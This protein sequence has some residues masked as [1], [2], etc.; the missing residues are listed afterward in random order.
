[1]HVKD[2]FLT[3]SPDYVKDWTIPNA[4]REFIQNSL[5]QGSYSLDVTDTGLTITSYGETIEEKHLLLGSGTKSEDDSQRGG[6]CEG[7]KIAMLILAREG[8]ECTMWNGDVL[9]KPTIKFNADFNMECL[10]IEVHE[11]EEYFDGVAVS[12]ELDSFTIDEIVSNTLQ[13]QEDYKR[14]ETSYGEVLL[15]DCNAGKIFVGG[16]FVQHFDVEHGYNFLPEDFKL[17]RDRRALSPFDIEWQCRKLWG[18]AAIDADE[19]LAEEIM[20]AVIKKDKSFNSFDN[21]SS[22]DV[23]ENILNLAEKVYKE[24]YD[25]KLVVSDWG[26]AEELRKAGNDNVKVVNNPVLV[27]FIS[28]TDSYKT[29]VLGKKEVEEVDLEE[30]IEDFYNNHY[31]NMTSEMED[32]WESLKQEI[33]KSI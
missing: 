3:L 11:A 13:M 16:L 31:H 8:I 22:N 15:D 24:N 30:M 26:E 29:V 17:D 20:D 10:A 23:S 4:V 32:D 28:K 1:M 5:D 6:F 21:N 18:E 7:F 19:E 27:N 12:I 9:W 14:V 2:I 33:L 25:G